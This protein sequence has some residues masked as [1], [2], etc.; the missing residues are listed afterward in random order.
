[1]SAQLAVGEVPIRQDWSKL[2]IGGD[3]VQPAS[4]GRI[5]AVNASTGELLGSVAEAVHQ[6]IDA[7]VHAARQAF[8]DPTGWASWAPSRRAAAMVDLAAAIEARAPELA[9]TV[10]A[11]NGMPVTLALQLEAMFPSV[12]LRYYATLVDQCTQEEE[13][14]GMVGAG[15]VVR[16]EPLGVVAAIVPWNG[17]QTLASFKYA[18]AL[19][20][21]CTVVI[22]PPP[23]TVLDSIIL[24][25]A[26]RE[27][28]IPPG[29]INIVPGNRTIGAYLVS[30][31][32]VDKV[33]FTG[34]TRAGRE[35]AAEC[36]RLLRPVTL[37]LGGK[38]AAII[39]EDIDLNELETQQRL[40]SACMF[41]SGQACFISSRILAPRNRYDEIVDF[42]AG[43]MVSANVGDA[44][45]PNTEVGP[46]VSRHQR[47][48]VE[49]Y[50]QQGRAEGARLV[51][52][53]GR[54]A[55]VP[56]GWF[57]QPTL[58]ADVDRKSTIA[59]QEIFGP[60]LS[61]LP[62]D[63]IDQAVEIANDSEYGLGGSIWTHDRDAAL[64]IAR[65]VRTGT[66]GINGYMP[67]IGA[68]FGGV[69]SSGLGRELSPETLM[70]YMYYKSIYL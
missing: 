56:G 26:V 24:A 16:R 41:N 9:H 7:A 60:V 3:W 68:P 37:E 43:L 40:F 28:S 52:G 12:M 49:G 38:S 25:E 48:R 4:S 61:V 63:T 13:R 47:D 18:P 29:V 30:H 70:H 58:F 31:P 21:G 55:G 6:D 35:I 44:L 57:V 39:L 15:T 65:R 17:P 66:I 10:S 64:D 19:A 53:G 62:Y 51:V 67:D 23:E 69:K 42:F 46:M 33:A 32:G 14:P 22:K 34:S 5:E 59:Q 2:F 1:M 8:D 36:G 27:T 45:D 54:P 11:Q 50:I 20:A